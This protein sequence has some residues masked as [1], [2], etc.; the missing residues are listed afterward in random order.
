MARYRECLRFLE[1]EGRK[2][3]KHYPEERN[4]RSWWK[5]NKKLYNAGRFDPDRLPLFQHL[6]DLDSACQRKR[7]E[8]AAAISQMNRKFLIHNSLR[9]IRYLKRV[10]DFLQVLV[11]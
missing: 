1:E 9:K 3:S 11:L 5:Y 7:E 10:P 8:D 6:L 2:P 4:L